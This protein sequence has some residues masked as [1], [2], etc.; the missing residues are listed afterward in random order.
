MSRF[1][2][3]EARAS[4]Y[5]ASVND[6]VWLVQR[7]RQ[8]AR[9]LDDAIAAGVGD[10]PWWQEAVEAVAALHEPNRP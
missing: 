2:A 7:V 6:V 3:I 9:V 4:E 1:A 10:V 8:L 5:P